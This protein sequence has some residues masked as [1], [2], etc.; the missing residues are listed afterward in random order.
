M[1]KPSWFCALI[2]AQHYTPHPTFPQLPETW[3]ITMT[4]IV[5]RQWPLWGPH[6]YLLQIK[7]LKLQI[8]SHLQYLWFPLPW[9]E[10][11]DCRDKSAES[12][13]YFQADSVNFWAVPCSPSC[14]FV[15]SNNTVNDT[16]RV[17]TPFFSNWAAAKGSWPFI[18][19]KLSLS[20]TKP[21]H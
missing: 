17:C 11:S 8:H 19:P 7:M 2:Q 14:W 21:E 1:S 15:M 6:I 9:S 3:R 10:Q 20:R 13:S 18:I 4:E 16:Q 5:R 12:L